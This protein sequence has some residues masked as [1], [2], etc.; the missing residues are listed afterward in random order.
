MPGAYPG[1]L[2]R[3]DNRTEVCSKCGTDEAMQDFMQNHLTPQKDWPITEWHAMTVATTEAVKK[4]G[5]FEVE[6]KA[7]GVKEEHP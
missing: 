1:A 5:D 6:M 3:T 4:L 2:S 7:K